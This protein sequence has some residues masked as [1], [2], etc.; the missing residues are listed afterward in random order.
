MGTKNKKKGG[1]FS[2]TRLSLDAPEQAISEAVVA[3]AGA[4]V[5]AAAAAQGAGAV[6]M[7]GEH[8]IPRG[9]PLTK[10]GCYE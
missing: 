6:I 7:F 2:G 4:A 1:R 3:D 8:E 9:L 5:A 10:K